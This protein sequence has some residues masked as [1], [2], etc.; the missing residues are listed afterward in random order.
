[1]KKQTKIWLITGIVLFLVG[2]AIFLG[3]MTALA[4]DFRA[5]STVDYVKNTHTTIPFQFEDTK[6]LLTESKVPQIPV[7]N[8]DSVFT[9]ENFLLMAELKR[10]KNGYWIYEE[11]TTEINDV[12]IHNTLQSSPFNISAICLNKSSCKITS[13]FSETSF[14]AISKY[15]ESII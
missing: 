3:T 8:E 1:M 14:C 12:S 9:A 5:L 6:I 4:W 11:S 13:I 15:L 10:Q 2:A 7:W